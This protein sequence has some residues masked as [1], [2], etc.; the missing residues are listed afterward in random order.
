VATGEEDGLLAAKGIP[1]VADPRPDQEFF[2]RSD[3]IAFARRGIV[4]HTLS[5]FSLH[6]DYHQPSDDIAKVDF[7][8]M[9][10]VI[11]EAAKVV[12]LL[13]NGAKPQWKPGGKP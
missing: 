2:W 9:A 4:A 13:A 11:N 1:I 8:H 5:S 3:N 7:E 10:T 6:A 12:R